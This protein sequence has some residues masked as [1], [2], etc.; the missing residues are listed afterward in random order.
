[1]YVR[2]RE[3]APLYVTILLSL[4]EPVIYSSLVW[5]YA[6]IMVATTMLMHTYI[7]MYILY[8]KKW[9]TYF[10]N[11]LNHNENKVKTL[12]FFKLETLYIF[13]FIY[14]YVY[15]EFLRIYTNEKERKC[16]QKNIYHVRCLSFRLFFLLLTLLPV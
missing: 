10:V 11:V 16:M 6:A 9:I 7:Y 2:V 4:K 12:F 3:R 14:I 15:I 1:V 8:V 13:I 5:W